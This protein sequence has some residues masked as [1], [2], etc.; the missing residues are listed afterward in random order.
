MFKK[1][2]E[3]YYAQLYIQY[4]YRYRL[5]ETASAFLSE[6]LLRSCFKKDNNIFFASKRRF[7]DN[8]TTNLK[9]LNTEKEG[10]VSLRS[11]SETLNKLGTMAALAERGDEGGGGGMKGG[12]GVGEVR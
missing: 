9:N 7:E 10:C 11:Y 3:F 12:E 1:I 8:S 4:I 6:A 2:R 5:A